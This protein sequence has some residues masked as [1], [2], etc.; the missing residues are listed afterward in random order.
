MKTTFVA[1]ILAVI[2]TLSIAQASVEPGIHRELRRGP[3]SC[4][5]LVERD[6]TK[7]AEAEAVMSFIEEQLESGR[8]LFGN[9]VAQA[10]L[11]KME[12]KRD[13][14]ECMLKQCTEDGALDSPDR[15]LC[16]DDDDQNRRGLR[17][18]GGRGGFFGPPR[19]GEG[20]DDFDCEDDIDDADAFIK[21]LEDEYEENG[22]VENR[23]ARMIIL[24]VEMRVL[25]CD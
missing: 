23:V 19:D 2:G 8:S 1:T 11:E 18:R 10:A 4:E 22:V 6:E 3:P 7:G 25:W 20:D 15:E 5:R 9:T 17:R 21:A 12:K 13:F 14:M 16:R 24:K